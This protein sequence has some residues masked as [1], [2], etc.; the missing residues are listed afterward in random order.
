VSASAVDVGSTA[1]AAAFLGLRFRQQQFA[2]ASAAICAAT[3]F[4]TFAQPWLRLRGFFCLRSWAS[5]AQLSLSF[6][7]YLFLRLV[8]A[9]G[10]LGVSSGL[11]SSGSCF[12]LP[13]KRRVSGGLLFSSLVE[14][15][16]SRQL[17]LRLRRQLC[18]L[19]RP[20]VSAAASA[21][22]WGLSSTGPSCSDQERLWPDHVRAQSHHL[23]LDQPRRCRQARRNGNRLFPPRFTQAFSLVWAKTPG[24]RSAKN[25]VS[26]VVDFS[27]V[28]TFYPHG[29]NGRVRAALRH[30]PELRIVPPLRGK[31]NHIVAKN[32]PG[33]SPKGRN[34]PRCILWLEPNA[35]TA[36]LVNRPATKIAR[37]SPWRAGR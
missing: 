26:D 20:T 17:Q 29:I 13:A 27:K 24:Q 6:C 3:A 35:P 7:G 11:A 28:Y 9:A 23:I 31:Q 36:R 30:K 1:S 10:G 15:Q 37:N 32:R 14:P 2:S 4:F 8:A 19:R 16:R 5:Q 25:T 21:L 22:G 34:P 12:S 18:S 33:G